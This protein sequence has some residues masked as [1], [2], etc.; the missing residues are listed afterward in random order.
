MEPESALSAALELLDSAAA[1][2]DERLKE[3]LAFQQRGELARAVTLAQRILQQHPRHVD[4]INFAAILACQDGQ[5]E[6]AV[7][8]LDRALAI[9][10]NHAVLHGN[11]GFILER[12]GQRVQALESYDRCLALR[13]DYVE[14]ELNRAI[15]L[16]KMGRWQAALDGY[17]AVI[18]RRAE[19]P[20]A[21]YGQG[22]VL[23][24]MRRLEA[25]LASYDRALALDA[26]HAEGHNNRGIVLKDLGRFAEALDS[27]DRAIAI[28][29][30]YAEAYGNRGNVLRSMD[31]P[32]EAL[33]AYDRALALK[34]GAE[35]HHNRGAILQQLRRD[36]EALAAYDRA[37]A[38]TPDLAKTLLNRGATLQRLRRYDEAV[39][40]YDRAIA[41][42]PRLAEAHFKRATVFHFRRDLAA[43]VASYDAALAPQPDMV[44][45]HVNLGL[46]LLASGDF[47]RGWP[48]HEWRQKHEGFNV[49]KDRAAFAERRWDGETS[50]AGKTLLVL[51]EQGLGDAIQFSRYLPLLADR[52]VRVIFEV[53]EPLR[54]LM[55]TLRGVTEVVARGKALPP[56]DAYA[57]LLSL[58][59][60]FGTTLDTI[61]GNTPYLA[62]DLAKSAEWRTRLGPRRG[63]RVGL[64]WSGVVRADHIGVTPRRNIPL[65]ELARLRLPGC[66][67]YSLQK[68]EPA[69]AE[70]DALRA[71]DDPRLPAIH[72]FTAELQDFADTAA[73]LDNLDLLISVD[74][75]CAHLAGALG[76]PVW[77][78]NRFDACWRWLEGRDDSPWYP[79]AKLYR[80]AAVGNWMPVLEQVKAD[81]ARLL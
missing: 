80:Q 54:R 57:L 3:A 17:A 58:P 11:K 33:A 36:E 47:A 44:I 50:L 23:A 68:G 1:S 18:A 63:L 60:A 38:L 75:S 59:L 71:A 32:D 81:L 56:F 43:A 67:F 26:R 52:G 27:C 10:P 53:H 42:S 6:T 4:T 34:P 51:S 12:L 28:K 19:V 13:P 31:R 62:A 24:E 70:L 7:L 41:A 65:Q 22:N 66:E 76:K 30:N 45:A 8:L 55:G 15:L 79:T 72:D 9:D 74:T 2:A 78:L 48:E 46:A 49:F 35:F 61:P 29:G 25:A 20:V 77:I 73:L 16:E 39:A 64:V 21:H 40:S 5:L 14:G 37:L 69:A